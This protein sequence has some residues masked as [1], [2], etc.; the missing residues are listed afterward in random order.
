MHAV[1]LNWKFWRT[2]LPRNTDKETQIRSNNKMWEYYT[3]HGVL[4][5]Y[6]RDVI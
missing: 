4:L 3:V 2:K 6:M 5:Y 1:F